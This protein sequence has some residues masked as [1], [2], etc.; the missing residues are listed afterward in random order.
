MQNVKIHDKSIN[1]CKCSV[2]HPSDHITSP[3]LLYGGELSLRTHPLPAVIP[4][5]S[6]FSTPAPDPNPSIMSH[7]SNDSIVVESRLD[8][9]LETLLM[10]A[11]EFGISDNAPFEESRP[12][13]RIGITDFCHTE[14]EKGGGLSESEPNTETE[15]SGEVCALTHRNLIDMTLAAKRSTRRKNE[16]RRTKRKAYKEKTKLLN[17]EI[18]HQAAMSS[19]VATDYCLSSV[20]VTKDL[21]TVKPPKFDGAERYPR[22]LKELLACGYRVVEWD[23]RY[24]ISLHSFPPS[25]YRGCRKPQTITDSNGMAYVYLAGRP[26][27][28][29]YTTAIVGATRAIESAADQIK[30]RSHQKQSRRGNFRATIAGVSSGTGHAV[31]PLRH[32]SSRSIFILLAETSHAENIR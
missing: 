20:E 1:S 12:P 13:T 15:E 5:E 9:T 18:M 4:A 32:H 26:E 30:F 31:R 17:A 25:P 14:T 28:E 27:S 23:G 22:T 6:L 21:L 8:E 2:I 19:A 24:Y 10:N 3:R 16:R 7:Q 11:L 29:S